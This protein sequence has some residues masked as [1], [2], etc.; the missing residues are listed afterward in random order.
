[1]QISEQTF[2]STSYILKCRNNYLD[3]IKHTLVEYLL[4]GKT[5]INQYSFHLKKFS[6]NVLKK[7]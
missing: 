5:S 3:S 6:P 7:I 1:M 2:T 4:W